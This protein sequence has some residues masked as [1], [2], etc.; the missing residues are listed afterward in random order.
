MTKFYPSAFTGSKNGKDNIVVFATDTHMSQSA[1]TNFRDI[2]KILLA[3]ALSWYC[4][5]CFAT[6]SLALPEKPEE[7]S[8]YQ[9]NI[10][11]IAAY[12]AKDY[13]GSRKLYLQSL[14][15][16][17]K[18]SD[19]EER[20]QIL[21]TVYNNLEILIAA[22]GEDPK[23]GIRKAVYSLGSDSQNL[24]IYASKD[25]CWPF[26]A[27]PGKVIERALGPQDSDVRIIINNIPVG[28]DVPRYVKI[29]RLEDDLKAAISRAKNRNTSNSPVLLVSVAPDRLSRV[30]EIL[31][32]LQNP[33]L[34]LSNNGYGVDIYYLPPERN[35]ASPSKL[36]AALEALAVICCKTGNRFLEAEQILTDSL[37]LELKSLGPN[38]EDIATKYEI[39]GEIFR[40]ENKFDQAESCYKQAL[41]IKHLINGDHHQ[42]VA[43]AHMNLAM[44][45][46]DSWKMNEAQKMK[47]K[48]LT[49]M[50]QLGIQVSPRP[51]P[52]SIF[53]PLFNEWGI[54]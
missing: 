31:A 54:R 18:I 50:D 7:P 40:L 3:I 20:R 34:S 53:P 48:A 12:R 49:V 36:I 14:Q 24:P 6:N 45:F 19:D 43:A 28:W 46:Y 26:K 21:Q 51:I 30:K 22:Q 37:S 17:A 4:Q 52:T 33:N 2:F 16:I 9:L 23:T 35:L 8:A 13:A 38:H 42:D 25:E 44:C 15:Q 29:K 5:L 41:A 1:N 39:L 10:Q 47:G 27:F 11:A 32:S